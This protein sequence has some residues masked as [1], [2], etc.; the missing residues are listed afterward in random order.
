MAGKH[1][2]VKTE[3]APTKRQLSRWEKQKKLSRIV[4]ICAIALIVIIAGI[5][6]VGYYLDQEAPLQKTVIKVNDVSYSYD[7]YIKMFDLMTRGV[8]DSTMLKYYQDIVV[9]L[10]EQGELLK[11]KAPDIG[12]TA[13]DEEIAKELEAAKLTK[14]NVSIDL[15]RTRII[16]QKY[17]E[18]Q[19][20]PK[21]PKSVE[22]VEVQAM[23]LETESMA[24]DRKQKLLLG[25][26]FSTMAGMLSVESTT[27][28]KKGY[29]GWIPQGYE[30][31]ALGNLKDSA[32]KD[33]I[34]KLEPGAISDPIYDNSITKPFGYWVLEVIEKDDTK[35]VHARGILFG[36]KDEAE[37]VRE[38][39]KNGAGWDEM[40]KQY[41]QD[42]SK[43][44]GGDLGWKI[45]GVD[46]GMLTRMLSALEVKQLS[47]VLRD[48]SVST[49]GGYWIVQVLNKEERPLDKS[50]S[51][52]LADEC[53]ST[54]VEGL[55]N[56]AKVENMLDQAMKDKAVERVTK[57]RSK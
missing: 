19:C 7:Y 48:D 13:T 54:W 31:Y 20:I 16:A 37:K 24:A 33:V 8:T 15:A 52:T 29:L 12:I 34:F 23:M 22:Q 4:M 3:R 42:A 57:L 43:D 28:S 47:D 49:K 1:R 46:E 11:E 39:L 40:A 21:Q 2:K 9:S 56:D 27:Q 53:L 18:Q 51:E 17:M 44:K 26:N 36:S 5:I 14:S 30:S 6:G 50:I 38:Q 41:S 25:D 32:I 35:G 10:I 45:P 55:M